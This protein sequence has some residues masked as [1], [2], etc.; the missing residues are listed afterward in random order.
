[1]MP[2]KGFGDHAACPTNAAGPASAACP[3]NADPTHAACP[4][5]AAELSD[6]R[7]HPSPVPAVVQ[8]DGEI[9]TDRLGSRP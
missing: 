6:G 3:T 7:S 9:T 1:M 8:R 2:E 4:V 5:N